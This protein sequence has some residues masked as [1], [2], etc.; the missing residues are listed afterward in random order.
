MHTITTN[1]RSRISSPTSSRINTSNSSPSTSSIRSSSISNTHSNRKKDPAVK[2][3]V[4]LQV[5][6]VQVPAHIP[7]PR[8][9]NIPCPCSIRMT[10]IDRVIRELNRERGRERDRER[11]RVCLV[12]WL[13]VLDQ[14]VEVEGS[15]MSCSCRGSCDCCLFLRGRALGGGRLAD[16]GG[17]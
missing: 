5:L 13:V 8:K 9:I 14:V 4:K 16:G 3:P 2:V 17:R 15:I 6:P 12:V 10:I 11:D 7:R 1:I